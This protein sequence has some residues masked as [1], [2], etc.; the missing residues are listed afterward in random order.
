MQQPVQRLFQNFEPL[1]P[2][3]SPARGEGSFETASQ[4][5]DG[6]R[7]QL[8]R[9]FAQ[10]VRWCRRT[11]LD[12]LLPPCCVNCQKE[13]LS[14]GGDLLFCEACRKLLGPPAW[15]HCSHCGGSLPQACLTASD[16]HWCRRHPLRFDTVVPLGIYDGELRRVVLR[17]KRSSGE[18]LAVNMGRLLGQCRA[19]EIAAIHADIVVPIPMFWT[20]KLKHG[21]NSA[22]LLAELLAQTVGLPYRRRVLARKR[23]TVRQMELTPPARFQNLR[24]AFRLRAGYDL[25]DSRVLLVDD[26]LTTGATCSA[27]AETLKRAGARSVA[28]AVLARAEGHLQRQQTGP[29]SNRVE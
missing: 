17:M 21:I 22:E 12:L 9:Y 10:R 3:P 26:V 19:E 24:N 5:K 7:H 25:R 28:V 16:C 6:Q 1:T 23:N 27:A 13:I 11:M 15:P 2:D 20:R 14:S 18:T 8:L 4:P 29:A